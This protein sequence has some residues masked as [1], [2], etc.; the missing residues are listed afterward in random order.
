[1]TVSIIMNGDVESCC[2]FV[3]A[4]KVEGMVLEWLPEEHAL[5]VI[6][7]ENQKW[8][9]DEIARVAVRYFADEAYPLVYIGT[10]LC[11]F[12]A[13]P[14]QKNLVKYVRGEESFG[15]DEKDIVAAAKAMNL[16]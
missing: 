2:T 7:L 9:P 1:M 14:S 12:G 16:T 5:S 4:K 3:P 15:I 6:D 8:V 13:L 11:A 10:T